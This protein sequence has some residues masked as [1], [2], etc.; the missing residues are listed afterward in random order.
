RAEPRRV[1][2]SRSQ[3]LLRRTHLSPQA[4]FRSAPQVIAPP[5]SGSISSLPARVG[6]GAWPSRANCL[7]GWGRE[8]QLL[9]SVRGVHGQWDLQYR[10]LPR[11]EHRYADC[12]AGAAGAG[13]WDWFSGH[14]AARDTFGTSVP[15][16]GE[17]GLAIGSAIYHQ[18]RWLPTE[19]RVDHTVA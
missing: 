16:V 19:P 2:A 9:L 14:G 7:H 6:W 1:L 8:S 11:R 5:V 12:D 4:R 13:T 15:N 3:V 10:Y 18:S 17:A